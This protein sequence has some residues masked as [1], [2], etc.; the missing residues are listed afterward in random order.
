MPQPQIYIGGVNKLFDVAGKLNND[1]TGKF[2]HGFMQSFE[3]WI[4]TNIK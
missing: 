1:G 3:T 4:T 2:L